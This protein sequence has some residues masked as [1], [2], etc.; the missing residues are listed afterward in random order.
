MG[1]HPERGAARGAAGDRQDAP[2]GA[3]AGET[4]VP[5][6]SIS[7]SEFVE[8]FVGVGAAR[9]RDRSSRRGRR[10]RRSSSSTSS[11]RSAAHAEWDYAGCHDEGSK[12]STSSWSSSTVS[13]HGLASWFSAATNRPRS[14]TRHSWRRAL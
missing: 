4:K 14:S 10:R 1:G 9:V 3:V 7:G 2:C 12:H 11:M 13:I 5:F 8:M 6:F